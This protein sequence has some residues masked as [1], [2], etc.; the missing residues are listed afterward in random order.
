MLYINVTNIPSSA[1][2]TQTS[3]V[4]GI[5]Q[6]QNTIQPQPDPPALDM[7]S[8]TLVVQ[9]FGN[10]VFKP[11]QQLSARTKL[12]TSLCPQLSERS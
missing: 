2:L 3:A 7:P 12:N 9:S 4:I 5:L 8:N 6:Q 11:V 1:E 10:I